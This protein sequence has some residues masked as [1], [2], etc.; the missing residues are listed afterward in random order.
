MGP[1]GRAHAF[2]VVGIFYLQCVKIVAER[3]GKL[4]SHIVA[5]LIA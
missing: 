2:C 5:G 3:L 1:G 4:A